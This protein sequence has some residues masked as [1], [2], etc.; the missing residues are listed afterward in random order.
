MSVLIP[1]S[2]EEALIG[3]CLDTVLNSAWSRPETV[4]IL[5]ISNGS[6]DQTTSKALD[7]TSAF[8]EKG[9]AL[10]VLDRPE[11]GKLGALNAGDAIA[12]GAIRVYLDADVELTRDLLSDLFHALDV[13]QARYA[14]GTLELAPSSS[15]ITRAYARIYAQVPFMKTGV[16]GAGLF[17]V[18]AA[19]RLRWGAFPDII[20]DD[21]FVRLSF[22]PHER[23]AVDAPYRWPLV[24]GWRNLVRVRRRQNA[25]VDEIHKLYPDLMKNDDKPSFPTR[26]KL[27]LA[28]R[29]PLGFAAY[30]GVA[31]AV[32]LSPAKTPEWSRGR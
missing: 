30:S 32:R 29:D 15:W 27:K 6:T 18:N 10:R 2:N 19:G 7:Y 1:A 13:P 25:G 26:D 23:V 28:L 9:W 16:P 14:S 21:T 5:V 8:A 4:E 24:E 11:G 17:A 20:S 31:L 3:T 22:A 12:R